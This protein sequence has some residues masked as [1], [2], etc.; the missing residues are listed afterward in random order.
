MGVEPGRDE[1]QLGLERRRRRSD[2]S[3]ERLEVLRVARTG[4]QRDVDR[5]LRLVVGPAAAG[6]ERPLVERDEEDAV[7]V[8]ED[9][10]RPVAVMDVEVDDRYALTAELRCAT[11]AAIATLLKRQKPIARAAIA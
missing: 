4:A 10:L 8:V 6:I 7:V 1:H 2:D 5:R 11:R 9:R 3:V